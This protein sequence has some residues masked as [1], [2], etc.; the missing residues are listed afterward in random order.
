MVGGR[1]ATALLGLL[2]IRAV[3]TFLTP[4]Q[5]GQLAM[6][7]VVQTFCGLFLV[8]PVGMHINR[9]THEW[10]DDGSLMSR[11]R[12]YKN[13]ILAVSLIG[14]LATVAVSAHLS[15]MQI[16]LIVMAMILMV[17]SG[18]WNA[19][20]IPLLNMVGQR[21]AAVG[22][23]L[24]TGVVGLLVSV[25]LCAVWPVATAWFAGQAIGLAF[26]AIG[27]GRVLRAS[28]PAVKNTASLPLL[29]RKTII[30]YCLP[31]AVGTG[32]MWLQLSG[33]RLLVE[34]Y[35]GLSLL[36]FLAVGLL[37]AGQIWALTE[38][39]A[40]QFL[41]PLF[42]RRIAQ[43]DSNA[44]SA[45]LSD[46]M[47]VLVPVYF[48]L[49]GMT[50]LGAPYLIRLLVA[51]QYADAEIF[52]RLG[53]GIEF[54]RVAAN[55]LSNAAHVTKSTR[56]IILPY[57]L[58]AV[59]LFA[60]LAFAGSHRLEV[61]WVAVSLLCAAVLMLG[62]M[63]SAM[64]SEVRFFLDMRRWLFALLTMVLF[65]ISAHWLERPTNWVDAVLALSVIGLLGGAAVVVLLKGNSALERLLIVDLKSGNKAT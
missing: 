18:S 64:L 4:E 40:Q 5:Y 45:A 41:T 8:N 52:V 59:V 49:A 35:W 21:G 3:T 23:T 31:L 16:A 22:W 14:G 7:L 10:W 42:Y 37:L 34:H 1:L 44:S 53:V 55:L 28:A 26:G 25:L 12:T 13:Y 63:W 27:A 54:C 43:S 29:D 9:H 36:G 62:V 2:A 15:M 46:L 32:F 20:W 56:A 39:F 47:N 57:A 48:V 61:S 17:N 30:T 6:L 65:A 33:Y 24:V 60:M 51:P 19:T 38:T 50:F 11:L 58:G